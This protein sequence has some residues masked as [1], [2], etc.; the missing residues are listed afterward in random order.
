MEN[1]QCEECPWLI[2]N[3][4]NAIIINHSKKWKRK[5]NCHMLIRNKIEPLWDNF[6]KFQCVG[7]KKGMDSLELISTTN[8]DE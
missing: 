2:K 5:H 3:N 7:N 8:V 4:N 1:K 6:P